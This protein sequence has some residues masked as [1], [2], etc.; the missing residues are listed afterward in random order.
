MRKSISLVQNHVKL[1]YQFNPLP[2]HFYAARIHTA[3]FYVLKKAGSTAAEDFI[4]YVFDKQ[5]ELT[6]EAYIDKTG[7]QFDQEF[8]QRIAGLFVL[9]Y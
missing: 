5:D 4:A 1:T 6:E 3:F 8:S 9:I 2:Y 7:A